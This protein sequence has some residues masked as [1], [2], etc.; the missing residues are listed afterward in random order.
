MQA[1]PARRAARSTFPR[2]ARQRR[3]P[4]HPAAS[5]TGGASIRA[6]GSISVDASAN[7][8]LPP[9]SDGTF[10]GVSG[11]S[12]A[13]N[14]ITFT[15]N[16]NANT[17]DIVTYDA[18][19]HPVIPGLI[20][21]ATYSVIVT[22][23]Q[24]LALGSVF[25]GANVRPDTD[26]ID[27]GVRA[28]NLHEGDIVW[29][30][31]VPLGASGVTS[32]VGGLTNNTRYLVHVLDAYRIKLQPLGF[33]ETQ[34]SVN[35]GSIN[36]G[37]GTISVGN[38]F[39]DGDFVTYYQPNT[40]AMFSSGQVNVVWDG[41]AKKWVAAT[42]NDVN[43]VYF[44]VEDPGNPGSFLDMGFSTGTRIYY[45][46]YA[47]TTIGIGGGYYYL[48]RVNGQ[49][50][51]FADSLCHATGSSSDC[52]TSSDQPQVALTL[53]PD[54]SV[55][56]KAVVQ[57]LWY[58]ANAPVSGFQD[59]HGYYVVGC[60]GACASQFKLSDTPG[61]PA[62]TYGLVSGQTGGLHT[63]ARDGINLSV[64]AVPAGVGSVGNLI[65]ALTVDIARAAAPGIQRLRGIG[66][67]IPFGA[68][69]GDLIV[70]ASATG[71]G[72]GAISVSTA[73]SLVQVTSALGATVGNGATLDGGSVAVT[74]HGVVSGKTV[75]SND[76][77]GLISVNSASA[78]TRLYLGNTVLVD[79]NAVLSAAGA[80][81]VA[82]LSELHPKMIASSSSGGLFAGGSSGETILTDYSTTVTVRGTVTA[83]TTASIE[84]HTA[85]YAFGQAT[86][87][88]GGFGVDATTRLL[89]AIGTGDGSWV[90]GSAAVALTQT[91]LGTGAA[92]T[93]RSVAV[94]SYVDALQ[95]AGTSR[96]RA[97]AFGAN[98]EATTAVNVSG[99]TRTVLAAGSSITS[100]VG[101]ALNAEYRGINIDAYAKAVCHCFGGRT[102]PT[103]SA[104]INTTA[105]VAGMSGSTIT[106][107]DLTVTV[108]QLVDHYLRHTDRSGGFLDFGGSSSDGGAQ[109][110]NRY[111]FWE[112][113]V[114]M[115]GEPNPWLEVDSAGNITKLI[116][117]TVR[118]TMG[119]VF[120]DDP[121][122]NIHTVGQL[123]GTQFSVDDILYNHG[124]NARFL[125]NVPVNISGGDAP[126][127]VI[128]GGLGLFQFQQTWNYVK[129]M[130]GSSLNMIVNKI[131]V[132]N[133]LN[134]PVIDIRVQTIKS[135][136]GHSVSGLSPPAPGAS[137]DVDIKYT[138]PPSLVLVQ[139]TC[140]Y[141]CPVR[142]P[143]IRLDN[144]IEN[145]IG[146]TEVDNA[147][148]DILAGPL[149]AVAT[150]VSP[151]QR[152][153][154]VRPAREHRP[155][156]RTAP[157]CRDA[158]HRTEPDRRRTG[159]LPERGRRL[160]RHDHHRRR[161]RGPR[162]RP[163]R[164]P[165]HRRGHRFRAHRHGQPA[166]RRATTSTL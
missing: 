152:T 72:G 68:T 17:G 129:L 103:A 5:V 36:G 61:G 134:P 38:S 9:A 107:A 54:T 99:L 161:R 142:N 94:G 46:P 164:E 45:A 31:A 66:E 28:H 102:S 93:G 23:P 48:I 117:V 50:Y 136:T 109:N 130:N 92:V 52:G 33:A 91:T 79:T 3:C 2:S 62:K 166:D 57:Q 128:W 104:D 78:D 143:F 97:T 40:T 124:A 58:A 122:N 60:G 95:A 138:F 163:H 35:A 18:Q 55:A 88:V 154:A 118:D 159:P 148:G 132:V 81:T 157:R 135:G 106:A 146:T 44:A 108:N 144:F 15:A 12:D 71:G 8:P 1:R 116:N 120:S 121:F 155:P 140:A 125:A 10:D 7:P 65:Y 139:N 24:S 21:Q 16:H 98:S 156:G 86:A 11:V 111:I 87:D 85:V 160:P 76:S 32:D 25:T 22:G 149:G 96:T 84:S 115:L 131:D 34:V 162:T 74:T 112:S 43:D 114:I 150:K 51:K 53:T 137:F 4:R 37:T 47:G 141:T 41:G 69:S 19:G 14:T 39:H 127:G 73:A 56:G 83:G 29:Y 100:S 119:H 63:F 27:F 70:S 59:G 126:A 82:A 110:F 30:S 80:V 105:Q 133:T 153:H 67:N 75:S 49:E 165:P 113:T 147:S 20:D 64:P 145:P 101:T 42:G 90:P 13:A 26:V 77:G 151:H 6:A 89:V 123:T 158:G